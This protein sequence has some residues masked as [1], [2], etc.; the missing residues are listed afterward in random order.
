MDYNKDELTYIGNRI[1]QLRIKSGLTQ[2]QLGEK[3]NLHYS[4]I[5]QVERGDKVPSLKT[6][7]KITKALNTSLDFLLE[8]EEE[9]RVKSDRELLKQELVSL[10]KNRSNKEMEMIL[11]IIRTILDEF[12]KL[13]FESKE[14]SLKK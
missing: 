5:G 6:L 1:R 9:Y 7:K 14:N 2:E 4:Y 10:F 3:A 13:K 11:N 12:D 8:P